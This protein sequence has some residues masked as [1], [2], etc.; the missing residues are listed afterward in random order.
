MK[1]ITPAR[2]SKAEKEA[3]ALLAKCAAKR[4]KVRGDYEFRVSVKLY[5]PGR[6]PLG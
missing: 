3:M 5:K 1:T 4:L 6:M 2:Y